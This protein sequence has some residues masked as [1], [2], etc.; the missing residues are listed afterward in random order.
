MRHRVIGILGFTLIAL[1]LTACGG[2]GGGSNQVEALTLRAKSNVELINASKWEEAYEYLS[3]R[4]RE[5][6][7]KDDY[8]ALMDLTFS[9]IRSISGFKQKGDNSSTNTGNTNAPSKVST[10]NRS[11]E[12]EGDIGRVSHRMW[13]HSRRTIT[14]VPDDG[15]DD[16]NWIH[17]DGQWGWDSQNWV[18]VDGEWWYENDNSSLAQ[19]C[20]IGDEWEW[21]EN[22]ER[23]M[24]RS[25]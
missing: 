1:A 16:E 13:K 23:W 12:V 22:E 24:I 7:T 19:G 20:K 11:V 2:D 8:A 21:D 10:T 18:R 3:P 5:A 15:G 17:L 4:L 6:C 25:G 14:Y 9:L